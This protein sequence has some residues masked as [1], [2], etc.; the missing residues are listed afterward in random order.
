M[1]DTI[2]ALSSG[3][4][5]AAIAVIRISGPQA[6]AAC[7]QLAGGV[8]RPRYASLRRLRDAAGATLDQALVLF[9]P[10]PHSATGEDLVE[11]HLHGGRAVV[12]AVETMLSTLPG[13][14]AAEPGAFTRR[15]LRNGR[16]DLAQTE[17]LADLLEAETDMQ[18]RAALA[19]AEG[20]LSRQVESWMDR[21]SLIAARVEAEIDYADEGDVAAATPMSL[22]PVSELV[23]ELATLVARP[24]VE[25]LRDGVLVALAGPPNAGKSSLFNALLGRDAAIVT[26]IAGTTRD[27]LEA[28]VV[29]EGLPYRLVDT[30]GLTDVTDDPIEAIGVERA[31]R[32]AGQADIVL[33]LGLPRDAPAGAIRVGARHDARPD[34]DVGQFDATTSVFDATTIDA[35]WA[36][37]SDRSRQLLGDAGE[38]RL[39]RGQRLLIERALGELREIEGL[40]LLLDAERLRVASR[41]LGEI[42]GRDATEAMLDALFRRFC[43]GK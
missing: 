39:H 40:D 38:L 26:P 14:V 12:R 2:Y 24:P 1:T 16:L 37:L 3:R 31:R 34:L 15:A 36:I 33:W 29:R 28:S 32:L 17:G 6:Q 8:P 11:L 9:F 43:L 35:L 27:V 22:E 41:S 23:A 18:R 30:A 13:L 7:Q 10:G 20:G 21:I 25:R 42:V 4:P 5:P 19:T